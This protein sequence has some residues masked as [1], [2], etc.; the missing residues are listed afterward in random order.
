[1][2]YRA[3]QRILNTGISNGKEAHKEMFK[4]FSHKRKAVNDSEVLTSNMVKI[5]NKQTNKN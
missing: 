4:V 5:K 2:G 3:K 1:M